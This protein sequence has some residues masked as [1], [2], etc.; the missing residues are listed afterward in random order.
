MYDDYVNLYFHAHNNHLLGTFMNMVNDTFY[1]VHVTMDTC[2]MTVY[3]RGVD[4]ATLR[5]FVNNVGFNDCVYDLDYLTDYD[6]F[7]NPVDDTSCVKVLFN[8]SL[9]DLN[10]LT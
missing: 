4:M 8:Q 3:V 5:T 1:N 6:Y 9:Y 7:D 2:V 10:D